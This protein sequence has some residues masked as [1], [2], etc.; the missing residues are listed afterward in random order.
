[1]FRQDEGALVEGEAYFQLLALYLLVA[2]LIG[3]LVRINQEG[4]ELEVPAQFPS[5]A[6]KALISIEQ[7]G[8]RNYH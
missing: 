1:M 2:V 7:D 6:K 8:Y 4:W 3:V 5:S